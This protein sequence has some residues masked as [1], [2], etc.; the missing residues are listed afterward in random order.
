MPD[1]MFK[2]NS[3]DVVHVKLEQK[4]GRYFIVA[5]QVNGPANITATSKQCSLKQVYR[6][7]INLKNFIRHHGA[8]IVV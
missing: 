1:W 8:S 5:S 4:Y 6:E 7:I 3:G 2:V